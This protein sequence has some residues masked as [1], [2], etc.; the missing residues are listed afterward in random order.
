MLTPRP[1][2][3]GPSGL[4]DLSGGLFTL[5]GETE[6]DSDSGLAAQTEK[7]KGVVRSASAH[8]R[9]IGPRIFRVL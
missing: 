4:N 2:R 7:I 8:A 1:P 5:T 6:G 3:L 9:A